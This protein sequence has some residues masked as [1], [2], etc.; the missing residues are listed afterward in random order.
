MPQSA[1]LILFVLT[2]VSSIWMHVTVHR[3]MRDHS[4]GLRGRI[5]EPEDSVGA[6]AASPRR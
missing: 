3:T 6:V 4:P 1:F 5:E 2:L